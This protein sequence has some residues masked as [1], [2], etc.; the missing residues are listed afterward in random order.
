MSEFTV[1]SKP[2]SPVGE[3]GPG[4]PPTGSSLTGTPPP[5]TGSLPGAEEEARGSLPSSGSRPGSGQKT[6]PES[7]HETPSGGR[8]SRASRSRSRSVSRSP[9]RSDRASP[10]PSSEKK[11]GSRETARI[12]SPSHLDSRPDTPASVTSRAK[13]IREKRAESRVESRGSARVREDRSR[14]ATPTRTPS[15]RRSLTH[16]VRSGSAMDGA[17][18]AR[19]KTPSPQEREVKDEGEALAPHSPSK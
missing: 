17:E 13:S 5:E 1:G 15:P 6:P 19:S 16:G 18:G 9:T 8:A 7:Y 12:T 10:K 11:P 14:P 4:T 2:Q 3:R